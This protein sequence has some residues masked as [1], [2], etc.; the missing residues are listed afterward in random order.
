M[1]PQATIDQKLT[2]PEG[3]IITSVEVTGFDITRLSP[4]LQQ[5]IR[6]LARTPLKQQRLEELAARIEEERPRYVAAVRQRALHG[7][8]R[9]DHGRARR[10]TLTESAR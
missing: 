4:G 8:A 2:V 1:L 3:T 5:E 9:R 10:I 6:D 7:R